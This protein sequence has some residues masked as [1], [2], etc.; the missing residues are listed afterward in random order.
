M[1]QVLEALVRKEPS[2]FARL[3]LRFP[4]EAHSAYFDAV[5]RGLDSSTGDTKALFEACR[6]CHRLPKRPAGSSFCH[7][8]EKL[9]ELSWPDDLLDAVA[10]YATEDPDPDREL[11]RTEASSGQCFYG[12]E[13]YTAGINCVRGAAAHAVRS[14]L[15]SD[16][17]RKQRLLP[18]LQRMVRDPSIAVRSCVVAALYPLLNHDRDLALELF[19]ELCDTED[20]LLKTRHVEE[21][22]R[23][24]MVTHF[25]QLRPI[26]ER[27]LCSSDI[28]V[29]QAGA[30]RACIASM[31]LENTTD[32][33]EQCMTGS[34]PLRS[35][36]AQVFAANVRQAQCRSVCE[37]RL[38]QLFDDPSEKVRALAAECFNNLEGHTLG[39]FTV[40]V[41]RFQ[42]SGAFAAN[43][44]HLIRA[45]E[46]TTAR[47]PD[48][49]ISVCDRFI[50]IVGQA[51]SD[52]Q[53]RAAGDA[54][55]LSA[56]IIRAYHQASDD[57]VRT[58]CLDTMDDLL[59]VGA[60]GLQRALVEFDR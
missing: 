45:L 44:K 21:F 49:T 39:H 9:D 2:R 7:L 18:T 47:L 5:L 26:V 46:A 10:W 55:R 38:L 14:L 19:L 32:L 56:L 54:D 1:F 23:Y 42:S 17:Q 13:I 41:E 3:V 48:V 30:R 53:S 50:E 27:M 31:D 33:E 28:E 6:R 4:D 8:V 29:A 34:E 16:Q 24:A 37:P 25:E 60:F 58:R 59:R 12:G 36:A 22:M 57:K 35:G 40:L 15:F 51:A 52:M 20:V 11:W 43:H